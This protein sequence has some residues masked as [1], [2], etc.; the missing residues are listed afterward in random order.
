[1]TL[2]E[3]VE[4]LKN[5]GFAVDDDVCGGFG[6]SD[7]VYRNY[8]YP[9]CQIAERIDALDRMGYDIIIKDMEE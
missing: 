5:I 1:M 4:L 3:K 9:V 7:C 8:E 6:C 2:S